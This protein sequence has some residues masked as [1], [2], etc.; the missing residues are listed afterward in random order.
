M[1]DASGIPFI[2][3]L[4]VNCTDDLEELLISY[5][6]YGPLWDESVTHKVY[7]VS[8]QMNPYGW[9]EM[10][11]GG[12]TSVFGE[13]VWDVDSHF[14]LDGI[15][16]GFKLIDPSADISAYYSK[17]YAS[18]TKDARTEIDA[19]ITDE[20]ASGKLTI[21]EQDPKCIHALGAVP[22]A[23]GG[24]RPI[25][26]ASRPLGASI[27][28]HMEDTFQTFK[29]KSVDMVADSLQ[30]GWFMGVTDV[31]AA[32]RSILIRPS[33]RTYQGLR[34]EID[35]VEEPLV[36]NFLSFGTRVAPCV[37]SRITDA[38]ARFMEASGYQCWNYLDDFLVMGP[39]FESCREAQLLLHRILRSLGFY[40]AYK[41]VKSPARIQ[42]YLGVE[43]NSIDM[44]LRL[45]DEK[46]EKL[47]AELAF[48]SGRSRT[49]KK[50]LQRLC[51]IL[52]HCA[53][54]VRGG[55][56]FSHR[57]IEMLGRFN[58]TH[59]SLS[60]SK[61]FKADLDW[62]LTFARWFNG[63]A[64][65]IQ[66]KAFTKAFYTDSSGSGFGGVSDTDWFSGAWDDNLK[67]GS[68]E[69]SHFV[70][71]PAM[72]IPDNINVQEL[73]PILEAIWRWGPEWRDC[74]VQCFS[75][76]TQ[77]VAAINT[78]KSSNSVSM[79]L[80]RQL[81]WQSVLCNCHLVSSHLSGSKNVIADALSRVSTGSVIPTHLCC[82][83]GDFK[84]AT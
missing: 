21:W 64:K 34:W 66:P 31:S 50:Q 39:T 15:L 13:G 51:G 26:D 5:R 69:H 29:Y 16:H 63:S 30:Q 60:L 62:W 45:P 78:G 42:I 77:V 47:H 80:L 44:S 37:F 59:R 83:G 43:L 36:D 33:D 7:S 19:I 35:G 8:S 71:R 6:D 58:A 72:Y 2:D 61:C 18:A 68:D 57:I 76:N 46:V 41:K 67:G 9:R 75:D 40:I 23:T 28:N 49:T 74:R 73:Y 27:N 48:F 54:L 24:F 1:L 38:V 10:L 70:P 82:R 4:K 79:S 3:K 32:Y 52:A 56:T 22:K 20:L 53:T 25:T 84:A 55:R 81:F 17:N 12:K 65:I 11:S 14:L